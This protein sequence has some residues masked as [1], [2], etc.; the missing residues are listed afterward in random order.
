MWSTFKTLSN[1]PPECLGA[2]VISMTNSASDILAVNF[3]QKEAKIKEKLN[4]KTWVK[5]KF[6]ASGSQIIFS[7]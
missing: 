4:I 3:L 2:Y 6:S 1:E 7:E 5:V